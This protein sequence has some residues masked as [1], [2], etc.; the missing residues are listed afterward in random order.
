MTDLIIKEDVWFE[1]VQN[2][3]LL[4]TTKHK[5]F[6][7]IDSGF[8]EC[9]DHPL[10][11]RG[12]P[13]GHDSDSKH[14]CV[15]SHVLGLLSLKFLKLRDP[16]QQRH[17]RSRLQRF[18]SELSLMLMKH[19]EITRFVKNCLC[20]VARDYTIEVERDSELLIFII[21]NSLTRQYIA[22]RI[23]FFYGCLHL[24]FVRA[25]VQHGID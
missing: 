8:R 2:A 18:V 14:L 12:V 24:L 13:S 6:I 23:S 7:R 16:E 1:D 3:L 17:Q 5:Q 22:G 10:V 25:Q 9:V 4:N 19:I 15:L 20:L 11:R 21:W